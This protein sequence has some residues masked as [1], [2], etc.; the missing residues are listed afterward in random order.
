MGTLKRGHIISALSWSDE[1]ARVI[2]CTACSC[3]T[4]SSILRDAEENVPQPGYVGKN[5][6]KQRVAL[7]GQNPGTPKSLEFQD[8]PYTAALR[9]LRDAPNEAEYQKLHAVLQD[10]IPQW[11]VHGSYFPL[12]E[13]SLSLEDIAYF[14]VVRCRTYGDASPGV[15][16]VK[17]CLHNHFG[18][19]L[20]IL[21]PRVVVFIGK[22]AAD[23]ASHEVAR[24]EI[25]YAFMNRQR[26]LSSLARS[27]NREAVV[28]LV[29]ASDA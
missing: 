17:S 28:R 9:R 25:P 27:Q 1:F 10:F 21:V 15:S 16:T 20:D 19:W 14:N 29:R 6:W 12:V 26:S 7:V 2:S 5:Y 11:P 24:R 13:C 23:R 4:D 18:H 3:S 22:W 8:R